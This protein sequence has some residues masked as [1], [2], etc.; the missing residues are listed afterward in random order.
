M[1]KKFN[2]NKGIK[3]LGEKYAAAMFK[4][5]KQLD[6]GTFTGNPVV[7][8]ARPSTLSKRGKMHLKHVILL[9]KKDTEGSKE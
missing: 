1:I 5:F 4:E 3:E 6:E 8:P 7:D 2:Y 9:I